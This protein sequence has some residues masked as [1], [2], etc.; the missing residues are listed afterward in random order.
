MR[1]TRARAAVVLV[2]ALGALVSGQALAASSPNGGPRPHDAAASSVGPAYTEAAHSG[3][4][5]G[6]TSTTEGG[7]GTYEDVALATSAG[8]LVCASAWVRSQYPATGASGSFDV[9]LIGDTTHELG[10]AHYSGLG[11]LG[12]WT[13][14]HTCVE[15]TNRHSTLRIQFYPSPGSPTVDMDDIDVHES[16]AVNGGFEDGGAPWTVWPNTHSNFSVYEGASAHSGSHYGATNTAAGGGGIYQ[17]VTVNTSASELIC[18]SAWLRTEGTATGASGSFALWLIGDTRHEAGTARYSGLGNGGD[19]TQI[20]TCVEATSSHSTLRIQFYPN[21]GS[22]TVE[23]D[24]VDVHQSLAVNGGFEDGGAPWTVWPSTHSNFSVYKDASAHSG[25]HYGATNT[26]GRGGGIYQ[27]VALNTS[28]GGL[29]CGSAWL[30]TEGTATGASGSFALWL[31]GET[32]HEAGTAQYSGLGNGHNW[33]QVQTCVEATSR[34]NTLRIQFYPATGS[35]TVEIDD[36]DVHESLVA[37]GGFEYGSGPWGTYPNTDSSYDALRTSRVFG[38]PP[39]VVT[40]PV[41]VPLPRPT[42]R[43]ALKVKML[44]SWTWRYGV[45]WLDKAKIGRLPTDARL[46]IRCMGRGCPRHSQESA[47]GARRVL[48]LLRRLRGRRYR[49]GDVL[50]IALTAPGYTPERAK[51]LIRYGDLPLAKVLSR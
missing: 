35:P 9:W 17:D 21:P 36:V 7:G 14:V 44:L 24:D 46:T 30:R 5:Y 51:V 16:L 50:R 19:W 22:P 45:T 34:H 29:I 48:R 38:P 11:N 43:R 37:N 15:A 20:Q 49:A 42:A 32:R 31:I 41:P 13:Q 25:S 27:D 23:I 2:I 1:V 33:T 3:S 4:Y 8:Q 10:A 6:A 26:A 28:A 40:I 18:G 12:N 47:T 39:P